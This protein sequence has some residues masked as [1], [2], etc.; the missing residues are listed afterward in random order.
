MVIPKPLR[1][2]LGLVAGEVELTRHGA[3]VHIEPVAGEGI[4]RV[5]GRLVIEADIELDDETVRSLRLGDQR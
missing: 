4:S 5:R 1:D 2:I 3:G